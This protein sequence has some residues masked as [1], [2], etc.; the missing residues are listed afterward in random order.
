[1]EVELWYYRSNG[2]L[3]GAVAVFKGDMEYEKCENKAIKMRQ[4]KDFSVMRHRRVARDT[5]RTHH[6]VAGLESAKTKPFDSSKDR[7]DTKRTKSE[8]ADRFAIS[9]LMFPPNHVTRPAD[10]CLTV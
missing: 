10:G 5:K 3:R 1:M 8:V 2:V 9:G 6:P 7:L 4:I